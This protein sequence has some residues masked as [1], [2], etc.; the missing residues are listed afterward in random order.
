[1]YL[2]QDYYDNVGGVVTSNEKSIEHQLDVWQNDNQTMIRSSE[3]ID[4][5][6]VHDGSGRLVYTS[7]P[8]NYYHEF[9]LAIAGLYFVSIQTGRETTVRKLVIP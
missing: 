8:S 1:M 9:A 7:S 5:I 6:N 3:L 2:T 4:Q